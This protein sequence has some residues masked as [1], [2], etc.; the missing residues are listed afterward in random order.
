MNLIPEWRNWWKMRSVQVY[1]LIAVLPEVWDL[2]V[3]SGIF[4]GLAHE[5]ALPELFKRLV[6]LLT[7]AGAIGRLLKQKGITVGDDTAGTASAT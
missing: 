4:E 6:Q 2:V 5:P 1:A 3:S 7:L